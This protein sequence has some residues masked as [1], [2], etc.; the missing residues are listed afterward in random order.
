L[1]IRIAQIFVA[2]MIAYFA[3]SA[4]DAVFNL[5]HKLARIGLSAVSRDGEIAF[6]VIY[7]GLMLGIA[8]AILVSLLSSKTPVMALGVIASVMSCILLSRLGSL[9][10]FGAGSSSQAIFTLVEVAKIAVATYL[11]YA[12]RSKA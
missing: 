10:Y 1:L 8:V 11:L 4:I 5:P 6:V 9:L 3:L 2:A 7:A 12:L